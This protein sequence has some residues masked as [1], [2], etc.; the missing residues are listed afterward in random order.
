MT[1]P[2]GSAR[3]SW[4]PIVD[5][6]LVVLALAAVARFLWWTEAVSGG[7]NP[8]GAEDYYNFLVRGWRAGHL[9]LATEPRPEMLA[10]ADPY[11]PAQNRDVRLG[12][13][14]FYHGH[15]YLYFSAAP[16]AVLHVPFYFLTGRELGTTTAVYVY[17]LVGF[18]AATA[19]WLAIRRRYFRESAVW[20]GAA[21][22]VMLGL[23]THL[24]V[25]MRRPLVWE[26]PISAAFAF[27]MLALLAIFWAL[28]GR[29]PVLAM[30]LA[31]LSFGLA[32][33]S[34]PGELFGA[35][36]FLPALWFL[37]RQPGLALRWRWCA[38]AAAAGLGVG[39]AA[40][41]AHN[42]A[43]FGDPLEFG[44]NYQLTS[45]YESKQ[46]H[47]SLSYIAHN[48]AIYFFHPAQWSATFPFIQA[49]GVRGG[50]EGYLGDWVEP[51]AGLAVSF[52]F[53]WLLLGL[54]TAMTRPPDGG[55]DGLREMVAVMAM[56]AL[57]VIGFFLCFYCATPRYM[58]EFAPTLTLLAGVGWLGLERQ[59]RTRGRKVAL[60]A[61]VALAGA[62]TAITGVFL[63]FDYHD[64][65][66]KKLSPQV[67][68]D[69][70]RATDRWRRVW[71]GNR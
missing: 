6:T 3:P 32:I 24:L 16:A 27:A 12:D 17:G 20:V 26:L 28:H 9:Y 43:R 38:V 71:P 50:P 34:R 14:S 15:Y 65:F 49:S 23:S 30:A 2:P 59:A 37:R 47:F 48:A 29:R 45:N 5:L 1:T 63:S 4:R 35:A 57:A 7:F 42:Y 66:L 40:V 18:L 46:Q 54:P 69:L 25:L 31:G 61:L 36:M 39:L 67:W 56:L 44:V 55:A 62:G 60:T 11:D 53:L 70:E 58:V 19:V 68:S 64:R 10:L 52:P 51:I 13:A 41:V 33:A 8:P 22:V 21:G